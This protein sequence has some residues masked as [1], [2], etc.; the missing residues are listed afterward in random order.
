MLRSN[1]SLNHILLY[2]NLIVHKE[3]QHPEA[4]LYIAAVLRQWQRSKG[5]NHATE[6]NLFK[7]ISSSFKS[8]FPQHILTQNQPAIPTPT[9]RSN[10]HHCHLWQPSALQLPGT[11]HVGP[12]GQWRL[13]CGSACGRDRM[14][15]IAAT[16]I[17]CTWYILASRESWQE[18]PTWVTR[19]TAP[20]SSSTAVNCLVLVGSQRY[21]CTRGRMFSS[22]WMLLRAASPHSPS[23]KNL[24]PKKPLSVQLPCA[25]I[26]S[27]S[28]GQ[29]LGLPVFQE[30]WQVS[31]ISR[32]QFPCV[33]N[34]EFPLLLLQ[35]RLTDSDK[36]SAYNTR[37][38]VSNSHIFL[39]KGCTCMRVKSNTR[40]K[41]VLLRVYNFTAFSVPGL[42]ISGTGKRNKSG[43]VATGTYFKHSGTTNSHL[44]NH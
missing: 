35:E 39:W 2:A 11:W 7:S 22:V 41:G 20:S 6:E 40:E 17:R 5:G 4:K 32:S 24:R 12:G 23:Q 15:W 27:C 3:N 29:W 21:L 37:H 19:V 25:H 8:S 1:F 31:P 13:G 10:C 28:G 44:S 33:W 30:P 9:A 36:H 42:L 14:P 18:A 38:S 43:K 16:G 26:G 34:A